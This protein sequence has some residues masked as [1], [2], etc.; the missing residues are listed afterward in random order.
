MM[1]VVRHKGGNTEMVKEHA[2]V[3]HYMQ[4]FLSKN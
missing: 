4:M 1:W 2:Y 3:K